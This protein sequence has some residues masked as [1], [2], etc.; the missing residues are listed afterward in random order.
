M[1]NRIGCDPLSPSTRARANVARR[2]E[3]I[4]VA[5]ASGAGLTSGSGQVGAIHGWQRPFSLES[6]G[7]SGYDPGLRFDTW[8]MSGSS[9]WCKSWLQLYWLTAQNAGIE[10]AESVSWAVVRSGIG[11]MG[12]LI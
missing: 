5:E 12:N 3:G 7:S 4:V 10:E 8:E 2:L 11:Q 9:T 6:S 1:P